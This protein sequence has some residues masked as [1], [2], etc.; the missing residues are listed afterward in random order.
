MSLYAITGQVRH[1]DGGHRS[2]FE[3]P[4]FYVEGSSVADAERAGLQVVDPTGE[5][6]ER[7]RAVVGTGRTAGAERFAEEL[8]EEAYDESARHLTCRDA[9]T[10]AALFRSL[11]LHNH[12]NYLLFAHAAVDEDYTAAHEE[13]S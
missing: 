10:F 7:A 12:A 8:S 1:P 4:T 3:T 5:L 13:W 9:E 11:Q 6:G 2:G